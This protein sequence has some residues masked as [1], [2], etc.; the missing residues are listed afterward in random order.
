MRISV[1]IIAKQ[2]RPEHDFV[3]NR[4]L[5][6][7]NILLKCVIWRASVW[8][9]KKFKK[10]PLSIVNYCFL[11]L[12]YETWMWPW[13]RWRQ[14]S[15]RGSRIRSSPGTFLLMVEKMIMVMGLSCKI[16]NIPVPGTSENQNCQF[17]E[18]HHFSLIFT[19]LYYIVT[20]KHIRQSYCSDN[21]HVVAY[22]WKSMSQGQTEKCT[23]CLARKKY[24]FCKDKV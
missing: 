21:Q 15:R 11:I 2:F 7:E 17:Y 18:I 3:S 20:L 1:R 14:S 13:K 16:G 12:S 6:T 22:Q 8:E 9:S 5:Q 23:A 24:F 10:G 19:F 4:A